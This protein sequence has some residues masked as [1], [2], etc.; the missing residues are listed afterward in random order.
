MLGRVSV[1]INALLVLARKSGILRNERVDF[2]HF[3]L[4]NIDF[5]LMSFDVPLVVFDL[6]L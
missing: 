3:I 5:S 4:A 2:A 1:C 6:A